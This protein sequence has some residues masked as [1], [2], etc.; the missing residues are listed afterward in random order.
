MDSRQTG[1]GG[2]RSAVT[3]VGAGATTA[4]LQCSSPTGAG[5][6]DTREI[7]TLL[8]NVNEALSEPGFVGAGEALTDLQLHLSR[9]IA[10]LTQTLYQRLWLVAQT[11]ALSGEPMTVVAAFQ[12]V[13]ALAQ[14]CRGCSQAP[15][16]VEI[17]RDV[18]P[19]CV[20]A[21]MGKLREDPAVQAAGVRAIQSLTGC[22]VCHSHH[23]GPLQDAIGE[24][25]AIEAL[26]GA[27]PTLRGAIEE[28]AGAPLLMGPG[29]SPVGAGGGAGPDAPPG[30]DPAA[31]DDHCQTMT[32]LLHALH[33]ICIG[34]RPNLLRLLRAECPECGVAGGEFPG[35]TLLG[36]VITWCGAFPGVAVHTAVL[37]S[38]AACSGVLPRDTAVFQFDFLVVLA[39]DQ[40]ERPRALSGIIWAAGRFLSSFCRPRGAPLI[41]WDHDGGNKDLE[42]V[43][44]RI[45]NCWDT[46]HARVVPAALHM[47]H[48]Y[49]G[50]GIA[51]AGVGD[52]ESAAGDDARVAMKHALDLLAVVGPRVCEN[53]QWAREETPTLLELC[54]FLLAVVRGV[55]DMWT[56]AAA[57]RAL[58][59][60]LTHPHAAACPG[61]AHQLLARALGEVVDVMAAARDAQPR[62]TKESFALHTYGLAALGLLLGRVLDARPEDI[63]AHAR[64]CHEDTLSD[65]EWSSDGGHASGHDATTPL[66]LHHYWPSLH[67]AA[68]Y[69]LLFVGSPARQREGFD[70]ELGDTA[71]PGSD[72]ADGVGLDLEMTPGCCKYSY[73]CYHLHEPVK[74]REVLRAVEG[75]T[76]ALLN[77]VLAPGDARAAAELAAQSPGPDQGI[78]G[79]YGPLGN[80]LL[81]RVAASGVPEAVTIVM[82]LA[83]PHL[84]LLRRNR[85]SANALQLAKE[86]RH[87]RVAAILERAMEAAALAAQEALLTELDGDGGGGGAAKAG[88]KAGK[89]RRKARKQAASAAAS[90]QAAAKDARAAGAAQDAAEAAERRQQAEEEARR[91]AEEER[92]YEMA[93]EERRRQILREAQRREETAREAAA[94]AERRAAEKVA[95][96][97]AARE[98]GQGGGKRRS[99]GEEREREKEKDKGAEK[100]KDSLREKERDTDRARGRDAGAEAAPVAGVKAGSGKAKERAEPQQAGSPGA[101]SKE[102]A[103]AGGKET[104][105][106]QGGK[107]GGKQGGAAAKAAA[108]PKRAPG[109][110]IATVVVPVSNAGAA[111]AQA[112]GRGAKGVAGRPMVATV[113]PVAVS[114]G[115]GRGSGANAATKP[116]AIADAPAPATNPWTRKPGSLAA[117]GGA[118]GSPPKPEDGA[119]EAAAADA[120]PAPQQP[121]AAS[122]PAIA[123]VE[124][125]VGS[126]PLATE[127]FARAAP[128]PDVEAAPAVPAPPFG[129]GWGLGE[130]QPAPPPPGAPGPHSL[131]SDPHGGLGFGGPGW[132]GLGGLGAAAGA[133][134][135]SHDD[136]DGAPDDDGTLRH[137][138]GGLALGDDGDDGD[139]AAPQSKAS[140]Q[141]GPPPQPDGAGGLFGS[142]GG[143]PFGGFGFGMLGTFASD[144]WGGGSAGSAENVAPDAAAP[145]AG[146]GA[147]PN[148][149]ER[150]TVANENNNAPRGA[151]VPAAA[152]PPPDQGRAGGGGGSA[153]QHAQ[154]G[155]ASA[156]EPRAIGRYLWLGNLKHNVPRPALLR[157]FEPFGAIQDAVTFPGMQY[158]FVNFMTR[159]DAA[160]AAEALHGTVIPS[161]TGDRRLI[162]RAR[163]AKQKLGR[164]PQGEVDPMLAPANG[165]SG[166]SG[167]S[168]GDGTGKGA[169]GG[170]KGGVSGGEREGR[171]TNGHGSPRSMPAEGAP[172]RHLWLGNVLLRPPAGAIERLF[173]QF[174]KLD[175]VRTFPGLS[176]AFVNFVSDADAARARYGLDGSQSHPA[177]TGGRALIVR[178]QNS[179]SVGGSSQQGSTGGGAAVE[180]VR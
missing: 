34:N 175:N 120:V 137:L 11:A 35:L 171:A 162:V 101:R 20:V 36:N 178:F 37:L 81:H 92:A 174:G 89:A 88:G 130:A 142:F 2:G 112:A 15:D 104:G 119:A 52:A 1:R 158:A 80:T 115:A 163:P 45:D 160:R 90:G 75:V 3:D 107:Q 148:G 39:M 9:G 84:D 102:G 150:H 53:N 164:V 129:L 147:A 72:R 135:G 46:S 151:S 149:A 48:R 31:L 169:W 57:L 131:M 30:V 21:A 69:M 54:S 114:G 91:R 28:Q 133:H 29:T 78:N 66:L 73:R 145:P 128:A 79:A 8:A 55:G 22:L 138:L 56:R 100:G 38:E 180:A 14:V 172:T 123:P 165:G 146:V 13:E 141:P 139:A 126:A 179:G 105:A 116:A 96:A 65:G 7:E 95:R 154:G 49:L 132:L 94:A 113:M 24:A 152:A 93:L 47:L 51:G 17:P 18:A 111:R 144:R 50:E 127:P 170:G 99:K 176:Y 40:A 64:S 67:A 157:V 87:A 122:P 60:V 33:F 74:G 12:L 143:S 63:D 61:C 27:I 77:P 155:H 166:G 58:Y 136:D 82:G 85:H 97:A 23:E 98:A 118:Q 42:T 41:D 134:A 32:D 19:K 86:G 5:N 140:A 59:F 173:A 44:S 109:S 4:T 106:A 153:K 117:G 25:G 83:G 43:E 177:I 62:C 108:A 167:G 159:A 71:P 68:D 156:E 161:I 10:D 6:P 70:D 168:V 103:G 16:W 125:L 110:G 76:C 26:V 121:Q 124:P